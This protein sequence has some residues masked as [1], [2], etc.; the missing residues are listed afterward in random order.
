[1]YKVFRVA[2]MYLI[3][4]EAFSELDQD[5]NARNDYNTLRAAR[6]E[7]YTNDNTISGQNL[8]DAIWEERIRELCFEGHSLWDYKRKGMELTRVPFEHP[9]AGVITNP[10]P[11]Q[12]SLNVIPSDHRWQWPIPDNE[13]RANS[14]ITPNPGY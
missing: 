7:G 5:D 4:A 13:L 8:K 14:N 1:M 2:E 3:R 12:S 6:I 9:V 11:S 10:G